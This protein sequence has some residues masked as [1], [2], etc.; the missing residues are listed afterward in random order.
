MRFT[1]TCIGADPL[2]LREKLGRFANEQWLPAHVTRDEAVE[3]VVDQFR[4][5]VAQILQL[6]EL[7][8]N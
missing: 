5:A 4:R 3:V 1:T 6:L 7:T 8:A 2:G